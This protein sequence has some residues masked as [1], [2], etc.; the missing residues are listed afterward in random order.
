MTHPEVIRRWVAPVGRV[1]CG[2]LLGLVCF[3][4]LA[5]V[6][7]GAAA[8][9]W[10]AISGAPVEPPVIGFMSMYG[11]AAQNGYWAFVI[12]SC[13]ASLV[14]FW[15]SAWWTGVGLGH[16]L[17]GLR[18][19]AE[20]GGPVTLGHL[21]TKTGWNIGAFLLLALPGPILGFATGGYPLLS[22]LLLLGGLSAVILVSVT[23]DRSG[24]LRSFAYA[25]IV[26]VRRRDVREARRALAAPD[27]E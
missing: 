22:L 25:G 17:V 20:D 2:S 18:G 14:V 5:W 24:R 4:L 16:A 13:F 3:V 27:R 11:R 12:G 9:L 19:V 15:V 8:G 23:L 1:L 10:E 6:T 7:Y 26:P 21:V